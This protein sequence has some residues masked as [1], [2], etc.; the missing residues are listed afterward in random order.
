[1]RVGDFEYDGPKRGAWWDWKPIKGALEYL[2]DTGEAMIANRVQF[3]RVYDLRERVLPEWVDTTEPSF[4]EM[5]C[6][7]IEQAARAA[8]IATDRQLVSYA[9]LKLK[10]SAHALR[11]LVEQGALVEVEAE[12]MNGTA[13]MWVHR[14]NL[15]LLE[16]ARDG[17]LR[18][19][20]TT[21]LSP[22]DSLFWTKGRDEQVWGF[23]QRLEA[24]VP[25][26]KRIWGYFSLPILHRDRLV[27]RF[28]PKLDRKE[29]TL[30]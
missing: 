19:E 15:P 9:F 10:E 25:A 24:Y 4:E 17:A 13:S 27:G 30:F 28:D 29:G 18:A 20:R 12:T 6:F 8:G 22:F 23:K 21:F 2:F 11:A 16:R 7:R 1:M 3:Q 26:P 14:D 5:V